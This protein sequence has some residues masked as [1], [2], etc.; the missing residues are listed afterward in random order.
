MRSL[1]ALVAVLAVLCSFANVGGA[2]ID[3]GGGLIYDDILGIT[4]LQD[5][6]YAATLFDDT[7][8][9]EGDFRGKFTWTQALD[10]VAQLEYQG[11]DDWRLPSANLIGATF[12]GF[13]P[14]PFDGS[15]DNGFNVTRGELGHMFY[16]NLGNQAVFDTAGNSQ[17]GGLTNAEFVDGKT[18]ETVIFENLLTGGGNAATIHWYQEEFSLGAPVNAWK[19]N[20]QDGGQATELKAFSLAAWAVRDGDSKMI[21][22]PNAFAWLAICGIGLMTTNR[23]SRRLGVRCDLG[24]G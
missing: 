19:F 20:M 14:S 3:R 18:G 23:H 7:N 12:P 22:E 4:W 16:N 8:G 5:A 24:N 11:Y 13:C 17:P 1:R 6:N 21:P 10:W 9:E 2:L 15:C